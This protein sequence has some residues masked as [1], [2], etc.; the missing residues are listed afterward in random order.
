MPDKV[1]WWGGR[2]GGRGGAGA[3]GAVC[4]HCG[5]TGHI[6]P[7]CPYKYPTGTG[8]DGDDDVDARVGDAEDTQE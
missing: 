5:E 4:W 3:D 8:D 6:K 7:A 2:G 1:R